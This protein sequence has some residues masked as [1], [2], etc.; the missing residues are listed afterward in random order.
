MA[1]SYAASRS[2]ERVCLALA[3]EMDLSVQ[4]QVR[5]ALADIL[6][7]ATPCRIEV[8]VSALEFI[9]S[10][11]IGVLV[12]ARHA[13]RAAQCTLLVTHPRGMV[14]RVLETIGVLD[15]LTSDGH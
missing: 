12:G 11:S 14:L 2:G 3:G 8:D 9:D 1:F 4:E 7:G 15:I 10:S 13:A 6:A 5:S